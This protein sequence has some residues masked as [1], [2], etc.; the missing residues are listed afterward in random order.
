MHHF[1]FPFRWLLLAV[2]TVLF[3][4]CTVHPQ[5]QLDNI[6]GHLPDLK[7]Q[8]TN[9]L[10]QPVTAANYHGKYGFILD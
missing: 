7:F 3:S 5:W 2:A 4:A 1:H 10:G 9:D 6:Q 8:L